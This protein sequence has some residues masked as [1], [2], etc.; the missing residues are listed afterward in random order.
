MNT[1]TSTTAPQRSWWPTTWP[2]QNQA[3]QL[4]AVL[5]REG[6]GIL[7]AGDPGDLFY[8]TKDDQVVPID[9]A[10]HP[11]SVAAIC[12]WLD[13]MAFSGPLTTSQAARQLG[14]T[15]GHVSELIRQD[16]L[17]AE[18]IGRDW[19]LDRDAVQSYAARRTSQAV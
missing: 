3:Y 1:S 6:F 9:G 19:Y 14:I 5:E 2:V 4:R 15:P 17:A 12:A 13:K 7:G 16:R 8:V 18:R 10:Y 11:V